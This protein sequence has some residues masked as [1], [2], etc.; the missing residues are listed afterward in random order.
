MRGLIWTQEETVIAVVLNMLGFNCERIAQFLTNKV[1]EVRG[2]QPFTI[3]GRQINPPQYER[4]EHSV[5]NKIGR[6]RKEKP[7]LWSEQE[8]RWNEDAVYDYM[9]TTLGGDFFS[10]L[11]PTDAV[12]IYKKPINMLLVFLQLVVTRVRV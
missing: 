11:T 6:T 9:S 4:T 7:E 1:A 2:I 10:Y 5:R 8:N 3:D 12:E